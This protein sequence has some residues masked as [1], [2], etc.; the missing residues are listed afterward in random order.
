LH[1]ECTRH[2]PSLGTIDTSFFDE[3][4]EKEKDDPDVKW[5]CDFFKNPIIDHRN[6]K[7]PD[8]ANAHPNQLRFEKDGEMG[9]QCFVCGTVESEE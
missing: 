8:N 3:H 7:H 2:N 1:A 9:Y 6:E 5:P 4:K